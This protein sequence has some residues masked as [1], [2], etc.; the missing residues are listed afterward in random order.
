MFRLALCAG[1]AC[2]SRAFAPARSTAPR[3]RTVVRAEDDWN[4]A[5]AFASRL[6]DVQT[7]SETG[8][9][10]GSGGGSSFASMMARAQSSAPSPTKP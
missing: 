4:A 8:E 2:F 1:L 10:V 6:R 5:D 3:S 9:P 7:A